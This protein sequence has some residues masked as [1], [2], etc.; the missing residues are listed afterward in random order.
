[1]YGLPLHRPCFISTGVISAEVLSVV[2]SWQLCVD[3]QGR[4]YLGWP[5]GDD[6]EAALL[7]SVWKCEMCASGCVPVSVVT[8]IL[9]LFFLRYRVTAL[10]RLWSDHLSTLQ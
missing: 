9:M 1:M 10:V 2:L 3:T 7:L 5:K 4:Q 6:A 8:R